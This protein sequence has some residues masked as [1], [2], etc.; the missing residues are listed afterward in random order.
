MSA[1]DQPSDGETESRAAAER[2]CNRLRERGDDLSLDAAA[3]IEGH[4]QAYADLVAE[5]SEWRD[6][7]ENLERNL[8]STQRLWAR[9]P[10]EV[11]LEVVHGKRRAAA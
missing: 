8:R 7:I 6:R 5:R 1:P 2:V 3:H 4:T 9:V 10:Y 11:R